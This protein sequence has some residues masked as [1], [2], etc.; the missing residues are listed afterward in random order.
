MIG[1]VCWRFEC[2]QSTQDLAFRL[3]ELGAPDG[4]VVRAEYQSAGRGRQ[5]RSWEAPAGAALMVSVILRP[6]IPIYQLGSIS[7]AVAETLGDIFEAYG[8][9]DVSIKWPNDVMI[10]G[11]KISGILLQTRTTPSDMAVL[12]IG[13]NINT[14][15]ELLPPNAISLRR[16]L[17]HTIDRELFC[18]DLLDALGRLWSSW[19]PELNAADIARIESR[20]WQMDKQVSLLDG[21]REIHGRI[22]GVSTLGGLLLIQDDGSTREVVAGEI[23]RGPRTI[24]T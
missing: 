4:T 3:A 16:A 21:N 20:L 10:D 5:G 11:R 23:V 18:Q 1:R 7:I 14:P 8:A 22:C 19:Q 17:S 9:T 24:S 12:G 15:D 6:R 13:I 2:T